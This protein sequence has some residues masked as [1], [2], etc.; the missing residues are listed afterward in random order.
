MLPRLV[1]AMSSLDIDTLFVVASCVTALLGAFL[2]FAYLQ[3]R[4]AAL[5]LWGGAYLLGGLSGAIWRLG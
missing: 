4:I 5:A 2:L 3:D 1:E